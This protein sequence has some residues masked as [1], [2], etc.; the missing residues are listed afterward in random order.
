[1]GRSDRVIE[2]FAMRGNELLDMS[3]DWT[4]WFGA[5]AFTSVA[6]FMNYQYE[7]IVLCGYTAAIPYTKNPQM[8]PEFHIYFSKEWF[9]A[10][11]LSVRNFFC[12]IFNG[13]HIL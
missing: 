13:S 8:D 7:L 12:E 10:M 6:L 9:E 2:F 4:P 11:H 1:M 5:F 3:H